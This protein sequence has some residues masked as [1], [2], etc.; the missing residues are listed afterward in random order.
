MTPALCRAARTRWLRLSPKATALLR[1]LAIVLLASAPFARA[2]KGPFI[3]DDR[4]LIRQIQQ[5]NA[6]NL[7]SNS[8]LERPGGGTGD[9]YRPVVSL[10]LATD[11]RLWGERPLGFHATNLLLHV[12]GALAVWILALRWLRPAVAL[13]AGAL[14]AVYP[15]HCEAVCWISGRADLLAGLFAVLSVLSYLKWRGSWRVALAFVLALMALGSKE[16]AA[17]L[18]LLVP[19]A[20]WMDGERRPKAL[21]IAG[22][23]FGLLTVGFFAAR[24]LFLPIASPHTPGSLSG[25]MAVAAYS[26]LMHFQMLVLPQSARL[27]YTVVTSEVARATTWL[28]LAGL[29]CL[30]ALA[31]QERTGRPVVWFSVAWFGACML[32]VLSA[33]FG[34]SATIVAGRYVYTASVAAAVLLAWAI[35][36]LSP[37]RARVCAVALVCVFGAMSTGR[38]GLWAD[39][40]VFWRQF[41]RD[42]PTMGW[43]YFNLGNVAWEHGN[44]KLAKSSFQA[45]SALMP[46]ERLPRKALQELKETGARLSTE[47]G[48][49]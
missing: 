23:G 7:F 5:Q 29:V 8:F 41:V 6:G 39:D 20:L 11:L 25:Q 14:F 33:A 21:V 9:Y 15:A 30:G 13:A 18:A 32:P 48:E 10:S 4:Y 26:L 35:H 12:L 36:L 47:D 17:A 31:W 46:D 44:L 43:G 3:W 1:I 40:V 37:A 45:A 27:G 28:F 42:A 2:A 38:S 49:N 24:A 19:V 22:A 16:T 34:F